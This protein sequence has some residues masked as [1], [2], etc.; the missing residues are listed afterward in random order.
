MLVKKKL[1][2][3]GSL[4]VVEQSA[5]APH[6]SLPAELRVYDERNHGETRVTMVVW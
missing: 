5:R 6:I 1:I 2:A 3:V 4:V